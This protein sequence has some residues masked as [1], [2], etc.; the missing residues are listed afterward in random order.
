MEIFQISPNELRGRADEL[1][2]QRQHQ[3]ETMKRLRV[4]IMSL[5][6]SWKGD[7]QD[8]FVQKFISGQSKM[9]DLS[10]AIE[11]YI[12]LAREAAGEAER[13]DGELLRIVS[14]I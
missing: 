8:A 14:R 13:V 5:N 2:T 1:E 3:L 7:A 6:E 9:D 12:K 10:R 11:D 4:L